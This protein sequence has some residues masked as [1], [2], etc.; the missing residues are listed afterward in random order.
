[1][2]KVSTL[3][4]RARLANGYDDFGSED[5]REGLERL[6]SSIDA[7]ARLNEQ[8]RGFAEHQIVEL[9]GWRL[10]VEHWYAIHPEIEAEEIVAPLI[11]L[12]LPRTGSTAFHCMLAEDPAVRSL[13]AWESSAPCPPPEAATEHS[14]PRIAEQAARMSFMD[15][16]APRLKMMLPISPTAPTECQYYMGYDFK[17]QIFQASLRIPAYV[18]WLNNDADLVPTYRYVKRIL[19]LLQWRCPPNRWRLKNPSHILFIEALDEVFPDARYWMTHRDITKVMPSVID[20]YIELSR[21]FTDSLDVGYI[22]KM[23]IDWTDQGLHRIA[24]FR[25]N[26]NEDRFFDIA[27]SEFRHDP[28]PV[29][30][31]LYDSLGEPLADTTRERMIAWQHNTPADKHGRY[32]YDPAALGFDM[33]ELRSRF[34]FYDH[35][36]GAV[37]PA[38]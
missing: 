12:G 21:P 33:A 35:E 3:L 17:S 25:Q 8:G 27:F 5:Y 4:E 1:M 16:L 22:S 26:G 38:A 28:M 19:K 9:L 10:Q 30:E 24:A 15:G 11:G 20:L 29:I 23:N 18:H 14:D 7:E 32:E 37:Q 6:V 2:D 13:R 36:Q 34:S 31:R